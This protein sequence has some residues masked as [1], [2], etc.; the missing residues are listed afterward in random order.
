MEL[1][2]LHWA[3]QSEFTS[4]K[5]WVTPSPPRWKI[6]P[7]T[8]PFASLLSREITAP[9]HSIEVETG[10]ASHDRVR[11]AIAGNGGNACVLADYFRLSAFQRCGWDDVPSSS[12]PARTH[13]RRSKLARGRL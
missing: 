9:S 13:K 10:S 8:L 6:S 3:V 4:V 12:R 1:R 11:R 7:A 2:S 5:R